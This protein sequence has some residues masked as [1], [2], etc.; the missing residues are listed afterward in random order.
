MTV[1]NLDALFRPEAITLIC[2][3]GA[4]EVIIARNLMSGGFKG[5]VMPV[6]PE[7]RALEGALTYPDIASLPLAPD[8]AVINTPLTEVPPC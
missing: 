1:R 5:P 8:L 4:S 3:G 7:R 2:R 6:D